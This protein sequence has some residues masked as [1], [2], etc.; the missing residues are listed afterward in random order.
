MLCLLCQLLFLSLANYALRAFR[1]YWLG[2]RRLGLDISLLRMVSYYIAG[3]AMTATPGKVGQALSSWFLK[4]L[5]GYPYR[6]T[7]PLVLGDRLTDVLASAMLCLIGLEA[8]PQ[9]R[10][11]VFVGLGALGI[12][13]LLL[14]KPAPLLRLITAGYGLIGRKARLFGALRGMLRKTA[15][16]LT[17]GPF[18]FSLL[19]ATVAW[20]AAGAELYLCLQALSV[21][22][23]L[24]VAVALFSFA[25][26]AGGLTFL[27]G[28]LGGTEV[29][30]VALLA[31]MGVQV[32][33]ALAATLVVRFAT[34]WFGI[35]CGFAA[36][37][38]VARFP[39]PVPG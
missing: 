6:L 4:R 16:L 39:R 18:S 29:V 14:A 3:F 36:L 10:A 24:W 20:F 11:F 15:R 35:A 31:A 38:A 8:F 27:P 33:T 5:H 19:L 2:C 17:A 32:E 9:H 25:N 12:L 30:M 13:C 28:G 22:I 23:G 37:G 1:F 21:D 7:L 34:L 26:L